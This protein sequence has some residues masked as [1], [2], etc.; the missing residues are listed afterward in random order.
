MTVKQLQLIHAAARQAG[1]NDAQY[2]LLLRHVG[3]VASSKDLTQAAFGE[4]MAALEKTHGH[5]HYWRQ[6]Q[7]RRG[8]VADPRQLWLIRDLWARYD[9]GCADH[10]LQLPGMVE[11][12][13]AGRT[14]LLEQLAPREAWNLIEALKQIVARTETRPSGSVDDPVTSR[15][16]REAGEVPF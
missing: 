11:R 7:E 2:R 9:A 14:R 10:A 8:S 5:G 13:S 16:G 6:R 3:H 1:L 12:M 4:V 15:D